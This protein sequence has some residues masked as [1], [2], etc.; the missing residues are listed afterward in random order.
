MKN[1]EYNKFVDLME[2]LS[3]NFKPKPDKEKIDFYFRELKNYKLNAVKRGINYLINTRV[4]PTFPIVGEIT[5]AM[6]NTRHR[7]II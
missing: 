5:E 2:K 3:S 7:R 6:S 1:S 4:Y